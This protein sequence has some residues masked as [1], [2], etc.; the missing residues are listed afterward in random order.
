MPRVRAGSL[1]TPVYLGR[2]TITKDAA[3]GEALAWAEFKTWAAIEP[4]FGKGREVATT[5][6]KDWIDAR[7]TIRVSDGWIPSARWR[8]RDAVTGDLYDLVAVNMAP[9]EK[10][11]ECLAKIIP[12]GSDGR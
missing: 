9:K 6:I 5:I 3:G 11:A 12:G 7:I 10:A 8:V 1:R 4:I 2:P